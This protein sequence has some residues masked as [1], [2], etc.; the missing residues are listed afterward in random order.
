MVI[1]YPFLGF[2][3]GRRVNN[4]NGREDDDMFLGNIHRFFFS[5]SGEFQCDGGGISNIDNN[6]KNGFRMNDPM[7]I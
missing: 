7:F 6:N 5:Y 4:F 3:G 2:D 1:N